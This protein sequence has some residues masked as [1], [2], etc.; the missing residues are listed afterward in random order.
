MSAMPLT[1]ISSLRARLEATLAWDE[2]ASG[3]DAMAGALE[4][5]RM[6]P[7]QM[8]T[9][10]ASASRLILCGAGSSYYVAQIV[11]TA[12]REVAGVAASAVPLSEVILRRE[13]VLPRAP[14]QELVVVISRS[15]A[16]TEA[17][18]LAHQLREEGW[19]TLAITCR[20]GSPL[21]AAVPQSMVVPADEQAIVMTRSFG[22]LTVGLLRLF[23]R[24]TPYAS[25]LAAELD[26]LPEAWAASTDL[27]GP[28]LE[29]ADGAPSR[30]VV[31]GGGPALGM[32]NEAVLKITETSQVP[33]N[34]WEPLEFRHGPISVC[35]PGVLV[36]GLLGGRA[37]SAEARVLSESADLGA[38][39]WRPEPTGVAPELGP[40]ARLMAVLHPLQALAFGLALRR[41]LDPDRPRHLNQVV[42]LDDA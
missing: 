26:R 9:S 38:T 17:V 36:V 16:T 8:V 31:L 14:G 33:A 24:S 11:A 12:M 34:A 4:A 32:A 2:A 20:A 19:R 29:L 10:V 27:V 35:E 21:T 41:G 3:G 18:T 39:I 15:G 5:A 28:A 42:M 22:A 37:E 1:G 6:A 23:A 40:I 13:G 7:A 30:V 25:A